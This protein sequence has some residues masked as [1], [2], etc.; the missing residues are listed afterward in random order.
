MFLFRVA[1]VQHAKLIVL[2]FPTSDAPARGRGSCSG[3]SGDAAVP[4]DAP[5]LPY[6]L[7]HYEDFGLCWSEA[8]V[9]ARLTD[10]RIVS[11][12]EY[13]LWNMRYLD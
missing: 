3:G 8:C 12:R 2:A 9:R 6:H 11:L 5:D 10:P 13:A 1:A 4:S 7:P